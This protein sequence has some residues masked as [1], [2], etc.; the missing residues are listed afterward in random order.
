MSETRY[1]S[2][3]SLDPTVKERRCDQIE[4]M[5]GELADDLWLGLQKLTMAEITELRDAIRVVADRA[6]VS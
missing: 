3:D 1:K 4:E 6:I 5:L 2:G